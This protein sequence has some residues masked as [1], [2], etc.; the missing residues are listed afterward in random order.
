MSI[1]QRLR[2]FG[3][4]ERIHQEKED[5]FAFHVETKTK[6]LMDRGMPEGEA[7]RAAG[8]SPRTTPLPGFAPSGGLAFGGGAVGMLAT[9]A[10]LHFSPALGCNAR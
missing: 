4:A 5:E 10:S 2:A 9:H 6:E 3:K 8:I 7:R 1:R